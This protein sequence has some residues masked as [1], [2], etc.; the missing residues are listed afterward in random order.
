VQAR[1][2]HAPGI[3]HGAHRR[4]PLGTAEQVERDRGKA[5]PQ[6]QRRKRFMRARRAAGKGYGRRRIIF[7][8]K[9][10]LPITPR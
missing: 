5:R 7:S 6:R 9:T 2:G 1:S 3:A 8:A 10:S 4:M